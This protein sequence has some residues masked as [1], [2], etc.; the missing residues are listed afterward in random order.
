MKLVCGLGLGLSIVAAAATIPAPRTYSKDV[1]PIIQE[2]CQGC[3]RPGEAAP[4]S[5]GSF[6]EVRPWAKA[7]KAAVVLKKMPPWFADPQ[8]GHFRNDR[9]LSQAEIDTLVA[10]VDGGAVEGNPKDLPAPKQFLAGWGI[11]KPDLVL[12]MP[13]AFEV[14]A[15]GTVD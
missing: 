3:H 5:F 1:A 13:Q 7:I 9:S 4:M 2:R 8:Y 10:W 12:E 15:S 6:Q 11:P 14:P